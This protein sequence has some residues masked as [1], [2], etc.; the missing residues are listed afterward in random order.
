MDSI[1]REAIGQNP[2][3]IIR[4]TA[5]EVFG[6]V[7]TTEQLCLV[8][9]IKLQLEAAKELVK[10]LKTSDIPVV[11]C[12]LVAGRPQE[13]SATTIKTF[14]LSLSDG[15]PLTDFKVALNFFRQIPV[16]NGKTPPSSILVNAEWGQLR[17]ICQGT[18][19]ALASLFGFKDFDSVS[20]QE[21]LLVG[22]QPWQIEACIF[23]MVLRDPKIQSPE[24]F[25]NYGVRGIKSLENVPPEIRYQAAEQIGNMGLTT[26]RRWF[27]SSKQEQ[28]QV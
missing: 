4:Q 10:D 1:R 16:N 6:K 21:Q 8:H 14:T 9:L 22:V 24:L 5:E 12:N 25:Q 23:E 3:D 2:P 17:K 13:I 18:S 19:K 11:A 20:R 7:P 15:G 28:Q 26:L 27:D